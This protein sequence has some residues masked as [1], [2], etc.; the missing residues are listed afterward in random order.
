M[1]LQ[2]SKLN[3][4]QSPRNFSLNC[5]SKA[6]S[7]S[8]EVYSKIVQVRQVKSPSIFL[9]NLKPCGTKKKNDDTAR[10]PPLS[11]NEAAAWGSGGITTT[12]AG[13]LAC[14][15]NQNFERD[16]AAIAPNC[17]LAEAEWEDSNLQNSNELRNFKIEKSQSPMNLQLNC[18]SERN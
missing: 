5:P 6:S 2:K 13:L 12:H 10:C 7:K 1:F 8:A 18:Q 17:T 14:K 15:D 9:R 16:K 4:S 3:K 11:R